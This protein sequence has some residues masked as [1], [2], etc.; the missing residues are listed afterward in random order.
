MFDYFSSENL[1]EL[2][3]REPKDCVELLKS[4]VNQHYKSA[5]KSKDS[6]DT[7]RSAVLAPAKPYIM[8]IET[9]TDKD[10]PFYKRLAAGIA[11]GL[12]SPIFVPYLAGVFLPL[13]SIHYHVVKPTKKNVVKLRETLSQDTVHL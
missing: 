5:K 3:F 12:V 4:L 11:F 13:D 1:D 7:M 8:A 6:H 2:D 10:Q 9:M